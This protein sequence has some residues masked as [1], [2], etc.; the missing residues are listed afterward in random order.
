MTGDMTLT[1]DSSSN[2]ISHKDVE[3]VMQVQ[4]LHSVMLMVTARCNN[5]CAFCLN[6]GNIP[7]ARPELSV[8]EWIT[9]LEDLRKHSAASHL[10]FIEREA[11]DKPGFADLIVAAGEMG[12]QLQVS[13]GGSDRL[14]LEMARRC[15]PWLHHIVVSFHG[16]DAILGQR[17]YHRQIRL[18]EL[19]REVFVPAGVSA[20]VTTTVTRQHIGR[21]DEITDQIA[22]FLGRKKLV[23]EKG[24]QLAIRYCGGSLASRQREPLITQNFVQPCLQ[25]GMLEHLDDLAWTMEADIELFDETERRLIS[26]HRCSRRVERILEYSLT[27][28]GR[29]CGLEADGEQGA[30]GFNRMT[31]RWDGEVVPCA[32][33]YRYTYG[34][35]LERGVALWERAYR[36]LRMPETI[37]AYTIWRAY[38]GQGTCCYGQDAAY[39]EGCSEDEIAEGCEAYVGEWRAALAE[40]GLSYD[41]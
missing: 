12:F 14:T 15:A 7:M 11:F 26:R 40:A 39:I 41:R 22:T 18:L 32:S 13:T 28:N 21:I 3:M 1:G 38:G 9:I 30:A 5:Q 6:R 27:P 29:P 37:N 16:I 33:S 36:S 31:I 10:F 2:K 34:N 24:G 17:T 23:Y 4:P 19:V 35:V 25:G 20:T 8:A